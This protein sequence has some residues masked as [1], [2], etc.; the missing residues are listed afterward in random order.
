MSASGQTHAPIPGSYTRALCRTPKPRYLSRTYWILNCDNCR[1]I[2]DVQRRVADIALA[3]CY[4]AMLPNA[5]MIGDALEAK[6]L[7]RCAAH[8]GNRIVFGEEDS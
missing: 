6:W 1:Y 5:I 2:L 7:A 8:Y 3:R 4:T